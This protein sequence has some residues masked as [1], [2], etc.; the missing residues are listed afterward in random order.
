MTPAIKQIQTQAKNNSE[1]VLIT[2]WDNFFKSCL[3]GDKLIDTITSYIKF[4]KY[5]VSETKPVKI[6]LKNKP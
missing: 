2:I 3:G 1:T 6:F 5:C 4:F